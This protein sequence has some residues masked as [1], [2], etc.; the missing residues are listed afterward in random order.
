MKKESKLSCDG[1]NLLTRIPKDIAKE[2]SMKKGDKL[3]WEANKS[4]LNITL[5]KENKK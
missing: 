4:K 2:S 1:K 3:S 5:K